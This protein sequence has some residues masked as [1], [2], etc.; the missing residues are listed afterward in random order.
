MQTVRRMKWAGLLAL[1]ATAA[2]A[3]TANGPVAVT[4]HPD[5]LSALTSPD[6]TLAANKRLVFDMWRTIVDAGHIEAADDMTFDQFLAKYF[7]R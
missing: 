6:A 4:A 5:P 7:A 2:V 1:A 3:A